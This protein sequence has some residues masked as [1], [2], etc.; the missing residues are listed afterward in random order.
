MEIKDLKLEFDKAYL[1]LAK[2]AYIKSRAK[3]LEEGEK[4]SSYFFAVEKRNSKRKTLSTL[5][6]DG[7]TTKD[8]KEISEFDTKVYSNLYTSNFNYDICEKCIEIIKPR[9][10]VIERESNL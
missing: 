3:W 10:K 6:I 7:V 5:N 4:N 1:E 9:I 8:P 2:G